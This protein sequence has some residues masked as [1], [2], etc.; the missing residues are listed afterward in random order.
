MSF[1]YI[2]FSPTK[3]LLLVPLKSHYLYLMWGKIN[4]IIIIIMAK[5]AYFTQVSQSNKLN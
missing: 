4:N 5:W 3:L 2:Q 1:M